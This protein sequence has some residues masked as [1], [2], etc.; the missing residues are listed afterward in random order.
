ML[1]HLRKGR[2]AAGKGGTIFVLRQYMQSR[3]R[4]AT[5]LS[6][7]PTE[8]EAPWPVVF[9]S[10]HAAPLPDLGRICHLSTG[11]GTQ[12]CGRESPVMGFLHAGQSNTLG[13]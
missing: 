6:Q 3:A 10:V 1:S 5:S 4:P 9:L 7:S 2:D 11:P 12:P 13:S 8:T